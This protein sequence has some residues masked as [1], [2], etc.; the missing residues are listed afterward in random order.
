MGQFLDMLKGNKPQ[1]EIAAYLDALSHEARLTET[2]SIPGKYQQHL[3]NIA[4]ANVTTH[5]LIPQ[6]GKALEEVIFYG[7]N[8]LPLQNIFQKRMCRSQDG[9]KIWGYNYQ[10]LRWLTGPGFFG[11]VD[12]SD[13]SG[14]VMIDYTKVPT[15]F[16]PKWPA[17]KP[18]EKGISK[19]VYAGMKDYLRRVSQH[20][21]I[22]EATKKGKPMG[23]Y[24]LLCRR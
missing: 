9:S 18:N 17:Y 2:Q 8:S 13:R 19:F 15:E 10:S 1:A 24:F 21:F 3:F 12:D 11:V 14:E 23:Q 22:G 16:P 7:R 4:K 5:D 6:N 20:V